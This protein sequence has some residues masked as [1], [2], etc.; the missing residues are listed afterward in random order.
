[1]AVSH[2]D[3][4]GR[5][6]ELL[7]R[8]AKPFVERELQTAY[9]DRWVET[10]QNSLRSQR[11]VPKSADDV[12]AWDAQLV[13]IVMTEHW[14]QV[15]RQKLGPFERSLL[16]ELREFRNSWAHQREFSFDDAYR[17]LD[18][19]E[20]LLT[21]VGSGDAS[22]ALRHRE[23]LLRQRMQETLRAETRRTKRILS[24]AWQVGIYSLCCVILV[25]Q[26]AYTFG[27]PAITFAV[28]LIAAFTYFLRQWLRQPE[29]EL[30]LHECDRCGR[31]IYRQPCPY[32]EPVRLSS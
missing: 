10:V 11:D 15:F 1:M 32:C 4:V 19:V 30:G 21:A 9:G 18:S 17:V 5:A 14:N 13:L 2:Q 3:R 22:E 12:F 6:L 25:V 26:A 27:W 7:V 29:G 23:D 24:R 16:S 8:G 20:R 28:M 31:I